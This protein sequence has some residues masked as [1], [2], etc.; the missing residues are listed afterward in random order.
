MKRYFYK[1]GKYNEETEKEFVFHQVYND[2]AFIHEIFHEYKFSP[3]YPPIEREGYDIETIMK[4]YLF[5]WDGEK[6]IWLE[7]TISILEI[8]LSNEI[9]NLKGFKKDIHQDAKDECNKAIL[10]L[11]NKL[12]TDNSGDVRNEKLVL[13]ID[14]IKWLG[15]PSQF[16]YIFGQLVD[17]GFIEMPISKGRPTFA[18]FAKICMKVFEIDTTIET[19]EKEI[20]LKTNNLDPSSKKVFKFPHIRDLP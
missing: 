19:L 1:A 9:S 4:R 13:S 5:L 2:Q 11:K 12:L 7:N 20:S 14:K 10:W 18:A 15:S 16:G 6:H 17:N 8:G 3:S